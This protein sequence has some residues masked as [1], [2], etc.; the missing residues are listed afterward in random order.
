MARTFREA[1][2]DDR[3]QH[4]GNGS[5]MR[6]RMG[7]GTVVGRLAREIAVVGLEEGA[8]VRM[9][10]FLPV[11]NHSNTCLGHGDGYR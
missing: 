6:W 2:S 5:G 3:V 11:H 4:V 9:S 1:V 8:H 7:R 10:R